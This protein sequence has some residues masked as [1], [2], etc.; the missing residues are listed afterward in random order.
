MH[1]AAQIIEE[2]RWSWNAYESF[3]WG[4]D[5]LR[6]M[7]RK[8]V[9]SDL[10][11]GIGVMIYDSLDTLYLAGLHSEFDR[12][13]L[14]IEHNSTFDINSNVVVFEVTIRALGGLLSAYALTKD[15]LFKH[16]AAD[17]GRRLL[18]AFNSKSGL[19]SQR[20]N[21]RSGKRMNTDT[22]CVAEVGSLQ[23]EFAYLSHIT[24]D[25]SFVNAACKAESW[26]MR[27]AWKSVPTY[28]LSTT[29]SVY[30]GM[31]GPKTAGAGVDSYYEYLIKQWLQTGKREKWLL[32][33]YQNTTTAIDK[34]LI[35]RI[36]N[37]TMTSAY[38]Q[39]KIEMG[40]L[41]CFLPGVF[42]LGSYH[43]PT[44][45]YAK[46]DMNIARKL[47][48][49][50]WQLYQ[51]SRTTGAESVYV[52]RARQLRIRNPVN[53]LRPEVAESL[54]VMWRITGERKY[55]DR[56]W[57]MFDKYRKYS[58]VAAGYTTIQDVTAHKLVYNNKM[59]TFWVAETLK[60]LWLTQSDAA[61]TRIN[62]DNWVFNTEAHP[63]PIVR[64]MGH[65]PKPLR[66]KKRAIGRQRHGHSYMH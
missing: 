36:G 41:D 17:L 39:N 29:I 5:E 6:P 7:T 64:D 28:L 15:E 65:C 9:Q 53:L 46:R 26:L 24:G 32:D 13:R 50:C 18:P 4:A 59:E 12:A 52:N 38:G 23:L 11:G 45:K 49:S 66:R 1:R 22:L 63:F 62:L 27:L 48:D 25:L 3:A 30:G 33:F 43:N 40:H 61:D 14:W 60:Y 55:K 57:Q 56:S 47:T 20:V 8:P 16:K 37:I 2:I 34:Y 35:R 51:Q 58:R 21:L 42:A 10:C 44:S 19:P 54:Y 31:F